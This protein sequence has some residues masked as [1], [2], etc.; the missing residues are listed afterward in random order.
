MANVKMFK[1]LGVMLAVML[2]VW[3]V[4]PF[5][6]HQPITND[7]MATAIILILIAI[8]YFIILFNPGWTKAVFFFE[9]IVIGVSGYMLLG[10]P[11]NIEFAVV[12][13]I[14]IIIAILA[15][16]RKLPPGILKWFYR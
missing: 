14:I 5:I 2:I 15:Y 9:G 13:L 8:A 6:R 11:Y 4:A 16:L 12:G 3:A 1:L 7:V 10:Y